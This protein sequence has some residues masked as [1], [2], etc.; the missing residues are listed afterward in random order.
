MGVLNNENGSFSEDFTNNEDP[1]IVPEKRCGHGKGL[2]A[3]VVTAAAACGVAAVVVANKKKKDEILDH[4]TDFEDE[5]PESEESYVEE[6]EE[7]ETPFDD[8]NENDG[9]PEK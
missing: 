3:L 5:E 6:N 4:W 2:L 1:N 8:K 7:S 9:S